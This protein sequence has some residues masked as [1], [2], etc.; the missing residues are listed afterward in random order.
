MRSGSRGA[1]TRCTGWSNW[2]RRRWASIARRGDQVVMENV[3]FS[4]NSPQMKP[5]V[6]DRVMEG[7]RTLLRHAA[8]IDADGGDRSVRNSAGAVCA[9]SDGA[10][11][12]G[13]AAR[14]DAAD[15]GG[16]CYGGS[17]HEQ[18][19]MLPPEPTGGRSEEDALHE[20]LPVPNVSR[21]Q[22]QQ[23]GIFEHVSEHIRREPA[24][25]TRLLEAMD[26]I[27]RGG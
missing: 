8:G 22:Q 14:A 5:P 15:L 11:G 23:Q 17:G 21:A 1:R 16:E 26:R 18:E 4:T 12:D 7:A 6:M 20:P 3:S 10:A 24:Q 2:R 19:R 13:D 9:A 25:S 27:V